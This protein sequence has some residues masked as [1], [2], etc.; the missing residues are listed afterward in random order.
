MEAKRMIITGQFSFLTMAD[1][2]DDAYADFV[3]RCRIIGMDETDIKTLVVQ[4]LDGNN[5]T[6]TKRF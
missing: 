6:E 3:H 4:D 5:L 2:N 1:N